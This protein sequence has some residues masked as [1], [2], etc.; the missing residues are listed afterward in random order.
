MEV[1]DEEGFELSEL[2]AE[3]LQV[4]ILVRPADEMK[5]MSI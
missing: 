5:S 4:G 1:G 3:N 2:Y